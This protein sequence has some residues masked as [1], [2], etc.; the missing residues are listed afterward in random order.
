MKAQHQ[1][2]PKMSKMEH[3]FKRMTDTPDN[4]PA[5]KGVKGFR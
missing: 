5:L 3:E 2:K 4:M 1:L